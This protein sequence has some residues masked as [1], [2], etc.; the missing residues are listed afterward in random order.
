MYMLAAGNA[1][2]VE[3]AK[4]TIFQALLGV[5]VLLV[6]YLLLRTINP[7][8]VNL[9]EPNLIPTQLQN[10]PTPT[11]PPTPIPIGTFCNTGDQYPGG[12]I[13]VNGRWTRSTGNTSKKYP[14]IALIK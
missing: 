6:S 8:L 5:G 11:T 2:K 13:C 3:D 4:D 7:D 9:K 1:V 12:Y 14:P 10:V